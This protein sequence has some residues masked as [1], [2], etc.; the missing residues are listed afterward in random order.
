MTN[1][2][3][4]VDEKKSSSKKSKFLGIASISFFISILDKLG[5]F[6]FDSLINGFFGKLF[7]SYSKLQDNF[8]KGLFGKI[9]FG[10]HRIKRILRKTRR[11]LSSILESSFFVTRCRKIS[12]YFCSIPLNF[13][14]NFT[15]FFGIYTVVVYL[16][17]IF[18]FSSADVNSDYLII[19][20]SLTVCAIPMLFSR[21]SLAH[22]LKKSFIC[23]MIFQDAFGF[24]NETFD[25]KKAKIKGRG[26]YM[27]FL[28]LL[29]GA[30]TFFVHP[31]VI[32]S[33][34]VA[35]VVIGLIAASPEIGVLLTIVAIPFV[36]M[37]DNPTLLL[38]GFVGVTSIF[39][40]LKLIR[41]K[42][43]FKLELLDAFVLLFG[44]MIFSSSFFSA[45]GESALEASLV[46]VSLLLGYFL[47]V[48]LMRTER[49][50][51]RC[52]VGLISSAAIVSFVG[53]FEYFF[54][55]SSSKWLDVSLFSDIK[56]RVVSLFENPNVLSTFV[57]IVFP[58][59]LAAFCITKNANEKV[60]LTIVGTALVVCTVFTWSRGSWLAMIVSTLV[61]FIIYNR[62][63]FRVFGAALIVIPAL[64]IILP[65]NIIARLLS[66]T[67]LSDSSISYRIYTWKGTLEAIKSY[68]FSGIGF[69]TEAFQNVYPRYAY[70]G[71][72]AAEH[73]HSLFLQIFISLGI[74]GVILFGII[75]FFGFQ[76]FFEYVK[77]PESR[78]SKI[79]MIAVI[80]SILAAIVMGIFDYIWYNYRVLYVFW[81]VIAIGCAFVRVGNYET[82]R[83]KEIVQYSEQID[84]GKEII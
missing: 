83:K 49:W 65:Q 54:S 30:M 24:S 68:F 36:S 12:H 72:E 40:I 46:T 44:I 45:G 71:I 62:K 57:V 52:V 70:S 32:I 29:A 23:K 51:K 50:V 76:K 4:N 60:L 9:L 39:Y 8:H 1:E 17:K 5:N 63:T 19:G 58:F 80:A 2:K 26:N 13:Y 21:V 18:L 66:I 7:T 64:P 28:G 74:V 75:L 59:V 34:L 81:I 20:A 41:G 43:V 84:N 69:G 47:V 67:N 38:C 15:L 37:F 73:S 3:N 77:N 14:G 27:L 55:G 78:S 22:S 33:A 10:N 25:E 16:V 35:L 53:I 31:L 82:D 6:I 56:L 11:F 42:R 48:N 61:F 79:Y